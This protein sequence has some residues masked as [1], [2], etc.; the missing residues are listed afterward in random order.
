MCIRDRSM[1]VYLLLGLFEA[2]SGEILIDGIN[3]NEINKRYI[4]EKISAIMQD[5]ELFNMSIMDN[6]KIVD[7]NIGEDSVYAVSYTH[8]R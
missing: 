4:R 3:I 5:S 8:L 7:D 1:I 6:V 2:T